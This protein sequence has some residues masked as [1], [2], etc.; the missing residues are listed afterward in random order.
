MSKQTMLS[1]SFVSSFVHL[2][3]RSFSQHSITME[4][5]EGGRSDKPSSRKDKTRREGHAGKLGILHRAATQKERKRKRKK[6][7]F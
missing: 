5:K 2:V 7:P 3:A 4:A 1:H 6:S